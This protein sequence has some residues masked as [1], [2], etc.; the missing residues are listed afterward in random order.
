MTRTTYSAEQPRVVVIGGG[1]GSSNL[2]KGLKKL[3]P[4]ISAIITMF[5][6]GG[7][8]GLLRRE[9]GYPPFGDLRQCL[10]ALGEDSAEVQ[11]IRSA[12]DFRFSG[13]SG[14]N[15]HSVGNLLLAA[16]TSVNNDLEQAISELSAF[17]KVTGRVI[18]V[19]L[20]KAEL[21]ATLEDG[22][23]I[24]GESAIDL[25][26][27]ELP[28]IR[29]IF[30]DHSVSVNPRAVEAILTADIVVLG[31]GDLYTSILPNLLPDG[32]IDALAATNGRRV[33]VCN[34]MTKRGETDGFLTSDFVKQVSRYLYP[35]SLDWAVING[36]KPSESILEA[37]D[38]EG[39]CFVDSD[40]NAVRLYTNGIYS[41]H[42]AS[43][44]LPLR[45]NMD[46]TAEA[47]FDAVGIKI[48]R[49]ARM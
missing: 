11:G 42:L 20:E 26:G 4:N 47:V 1:S 48:K 43:D 38:G 39:A 37:Y 18:P 16:L 2:L 30:L 49:D 5:D 25:R 22:R 33:Y 31:P 13:D 7:S 21:C 41:A 45:H 28:A 29:D 23:V 32:M 44:D 27:D 8:S 15:G 3:T 10:L 17:L 12:L 19:T 46:R 35:A 14:L 9:F 36:Q 24:T 6:N 34:L 40:L